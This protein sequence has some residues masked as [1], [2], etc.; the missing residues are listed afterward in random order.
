MKSIHNQNVAELAFVNLL[1][2]TFDVWSSHAFGY[3]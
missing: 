3:L 1:T 2:A